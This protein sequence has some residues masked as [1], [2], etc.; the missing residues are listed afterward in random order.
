MLNELLEYQQYINRTFKPDSA[1]IRLKYKP[2]ISN[3]FSGIERAMVMVGR[4][5]LFEKGGVDSARAE[6]AMRL[7][8]GGKEEPLD[9]EIK[10]IKNWLPDYICTVFLRRQIDSFKNRRNF[11]VSEVIIPDAW[12][13]IVKSIKCELDKESQNDTPDHE[14]L[15][16]LIEQLEEH[17]DEVLKNGKGNKDAA[18]SELQDVVKKYVKPIIIAFKKAESRKL[19]RSDRSIYQEEK[20]PNKVRSFLNAF[21]GGLDFPCELE[22]LVLG[23][24]NAGIDDIIHNAEELDEKQKD[25][26]EYKSAYESWIS[27]VVNCAFSLKKLETKRR[28]Y[29]K[30]MFRE[31]FSVKETGKYNNDFKA[32]TYDGIIAK[33]FNLGELRRYYLCCTDESIISDIKNCNSEK[34]RDIILKTVAAWLLNRTNGQSFVLVNKTDIINWLKDVSKPDD[35][36][37]EKHKDNKPYTDKCGNELFHFK[38]V[39]KNTV[40]LFIGVATGKKDEPLKDASDNMAFI[41]CFEVVE[42]SQLD[43]WLAEHSDGVFYRDDGS[44][45]Y[46]QKNVR[47]KPT[48]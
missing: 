41:N 38:L 6:N 20:L 13:R 24:E 18:C 12:G 37:P 36:H 21:C 48:L 44:G 32:I 14:I 45:E 31:T 33:G 26:P 43:E 9:E 30:Q 10:L 7:W 34:D 8:C 2:L 23:M 15:K 27:P 11:A 40:K 35:Y 28:D 47:Y 25:F 4:H 1:D 46:L 22:D 17:V 39:G 16:Q 29:A 19:R 3:D 5:F 42:E